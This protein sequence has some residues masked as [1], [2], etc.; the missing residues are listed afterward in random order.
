ML[1]TAFGDIYDYKAIFCSYG[2]ISL[3]I[4]EY[5]PT[6]LSSN[7]LLYLAQ[8]IH[9]STLSPS[10]LISS[11][12]SISFGRVWILFSWCRIMTETYFLQLC[13]PTMPDVMREIWGLDRHWQNKDGCYLGTNAG[14]YFMRFFGQDCSWRS[15]SLWFYLI[16]LIISPIYDIHNTFYNKFRS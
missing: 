12:S 13:R 9:L 16:L 11:I 7:Q 3:A 1:I 6:I 4:C 14:S 15:L 2:P 10:S 8:A 5:P